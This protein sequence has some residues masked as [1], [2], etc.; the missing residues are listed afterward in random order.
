MD[1]FLV[2]L[3]AEVVMH[4]GDHVFAVAEG[5]I[6]HG[7]CDRSFTDGDSGGRRKAPVACNNVINPR[8]NKFDETRATFVEDELLVVES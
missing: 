8:K 6:P 5:L 7:G 1:V 3:V 2:I 4:G